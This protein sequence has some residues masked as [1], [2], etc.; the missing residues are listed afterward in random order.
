[1]FIV[2]T[3]LL[4]VLGSEIVT[5]A[6]SVASCLAGIGP[7]LSS[8]GPMGNYSGLPGLSKIVLSFIMILGRLEIVTVF[9][10]FTRSFWRL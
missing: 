1:M 4:I 10:L 9:V 3:I 6:T 8:V 5:S 2:G 7:G